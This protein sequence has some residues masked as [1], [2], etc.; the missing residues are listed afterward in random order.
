[1]V[2]KWAGDQLEIQRVE[3]IVTQ[4]VLQLRGEKRSENEEPTT[5]AGGLR[6]VKP[7]GRQRVRSVLTANGQQGST[8]EGDQRDNGTEAG[9]TVIT[10][11]YSTLSDHSKK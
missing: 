11:C 3:G 10:V 9:R 1:M 7:S 6:W 5:R 4:R 2:A 8:D